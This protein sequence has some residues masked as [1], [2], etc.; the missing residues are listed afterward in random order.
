MK[1][2]EDEKID[3]LF[4]QF[5]IQDVDQKINDQV[6][7]I[8]HLTENNE[9]ACQLYK[10]KREKRENLKL[11]NSELEHQ[12]SDFDKKISKMQNSINNI[13]DKIRTELDHFKV[14]DELECEDNNIFEDVLGIMQTNYQTKIDLVNK[15][16][17]NLSQSVLDKENQLD[18]INFKIKEIQRKIHQ[19]DNLNKQF[20]KKSLNKIDSLKN[21]NEEELPNLDLNSLKVF[22]VSRQ[23][24]KNDANKAENTKR[25]VRVQNRAVQL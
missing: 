6:R 5:S 19:Y 20:M 22:L 4:S 14:S 3:H 8:K 7:I 1:N 2:L 9:D 11:L 12:N 25:T 21:I 15:N 17:K 23:A 10:N 24:F 16:I 18:L 13:T